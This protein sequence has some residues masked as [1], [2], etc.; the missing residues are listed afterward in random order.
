VQPGARPWPA[1]EGGQ[2]R[3]GGRRRVQARRV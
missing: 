3:R 1:G 2:R